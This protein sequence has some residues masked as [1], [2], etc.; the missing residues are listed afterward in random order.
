MHNNFPNDN[1]TNDFLTKLRELENP[2]KKNED[3]SHSNVYDDKIKQ[4]LKTS[5]RVILSRYH[6]PL[7]MVW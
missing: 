3:D 4:S 6:D 7:T 2:R 5:E 1:L